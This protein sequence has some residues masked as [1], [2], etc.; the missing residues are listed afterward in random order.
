[1]RYLLTTLLLSLTLCLS[2]CSAADKQMEGT[3][4]GVLANAACG[5]TVAVTNPKTSAVVGDICG[6]VAPY[7]QPIVNWIAGM[8][9]TT[10]GVALVAKARAEWAPLTPAGRPLGTMDPRWAGATTAVL[11]ALPATWKPTD[12]IPENLRAVVLAKRGPK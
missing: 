2:G 5:V 4:A 10:A 9:P 11:Q 8:V 12:P 3:L 1:M 6:V 7:I